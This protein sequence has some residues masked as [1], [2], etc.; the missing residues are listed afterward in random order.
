MAAYTPAVGLPGNR[1]VV[2]VGGRVLGSQRE[3]LEGTSV[4][5]AVVVLGVI[6]QRC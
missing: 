5:V 6:R 1:E 2:A 3:V 4:G